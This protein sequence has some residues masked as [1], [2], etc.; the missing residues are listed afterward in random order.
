LSAKKDLE[1]ARISRD[2]AVE[3]ARL[4]QESD[5][6]RAAA[7]AVRGSEILVPVRVAKY[8]VEVTAQVVQPGQY[9]LRAVD[10][11]PT[12]PAVYW[13]DVSF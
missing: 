9:D 12:Q 1:V 4:Q 5:S 7:Q 2:Q 10:E 6:D 3:L 11:L 8:I 13:R